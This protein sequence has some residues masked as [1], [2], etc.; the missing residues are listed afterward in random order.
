MK[1]VSLD[2]I[3]GG[4]SLQQHWSL[5]YRP[6]ANGDD[7]HQSPPSCPMATTKPLSDR[8]WFR[9]FLVLPG[10]VQNTTIPINPAAFAP[11]PLDPGG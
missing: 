2:K 5:A 8:T 9:E 1:G 6:S 10:G 7:E 11:P 3:V 4:W